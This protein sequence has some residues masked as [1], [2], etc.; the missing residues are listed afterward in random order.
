M[1]KVF[2]F[3]AAIWLGTVGAL[4]QA[5]VDFQNYIPG[6]LRV[7]VYGVEPGNPFE[8]KT[9]NTSNGIPAGSQTYGGPVLAGAG[10][11]A[12]LWGVGGENTS[13]AALQPLGTSCFRTGVAAGRICVSLLPWGNAVSVPGAPLDGSVNVGTFQVR[14]W[15]NHGGS[16]TSWTQALATPLVPCGASEVFTVG[17]L[18]GPLTGNPTPPA[19]ALTG[20]RSFNLSLGLGPSLLLINDIAVAEGSNGTANA[21]FP[22]TLL[23]PRDQVVTVDYATADGTALAGSDYLATNGTLTFQPG[24]TNKFINVVLTADVSPEA[25][26]NFLLILSNATNAGILRS[27][28]RATI[29]EIRVEGITVDVAVTFHTVAGHTYVLEKTD[30]AMTGGWT[31]VA[32]ATMIAG[33]GGTVTAYD[34]GSGCPSGQ[35]YRA[36]LVQ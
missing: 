14:V 18:G 34:R 10:F 2:P 20:M 19:P 16:I 9:G 25:D 21:V 17:P 27:P 13:E 7:P 6:V 31:P 35:L 32:G 23:P 11:T 36:R 29:T 15:D 1:R 3:L 4:A 24:E 8:T 33:T 30:M 12:Q 22:V 26:E 5:T 28:A